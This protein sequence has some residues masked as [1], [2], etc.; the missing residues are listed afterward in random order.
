MHREAARSRGES[1]PETPG[2][3]LVRAGRKGQKTGGGWYDYQPGDRTPR[4]SA[5][6]ARLLA[7]MIVGKRAMTS[8]EIADRLIGIMAVE[9]QAILDESIAAS[10]SDIDLVQVHGYGFPRWRG[11]PMFLR[12]RKQA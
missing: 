2:D 1:V 8:A 9:G 4:R 3:I 6:V 11:G 7:P 5:E 10:A 12:A